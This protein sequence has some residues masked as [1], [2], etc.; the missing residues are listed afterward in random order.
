MAKKSIGNKK[1]RITLETPTQAAEFLVSLFYPTD[2]WTNPA[3]ETL[4]YLHP[5]A[6]YLASTVNTGAWRAEWE[7]I[8]RVVFELYAQP[9]SDEHYELRSPAASRRGGNELKTETWSAYCHMSKT[10]P[11][12]ITAHDDGLPF[13]YVHEESGT[14]VTAGKIEPERMLGFMARF[15][16]RTVG[17][18]GTNW[19]VDAEYSKKYGREWLRDGG[20]RLNYLVMSD[21]C[22][23]G[24][25]S[26]GW[27]LD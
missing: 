22:V 25:P 10:M 14:V 2:H 3:P 16:L 11:G 18:V 20:L 17:V 21:A 1:T 4:L 23:E 5:D 15:E 7:P 26:G 27:Y 13:C 8:D 6:R 9:E 19:I 12:N 24:L